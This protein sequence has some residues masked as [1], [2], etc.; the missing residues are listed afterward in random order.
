MYLKMYSAREMSGFY[1]SFWTVTIVITVQ[2]RNCD[3]RIIK[4]HFQNVKKK[5][6]L[7]NVVRHRI[8]F[9]QVVESIVEF[10]TT[11]SSVKT[12]LVRENMFNVRAQ[13]KDKISNSDFPTQV[14]RRSLVPETPSTHERLCGWR[15]IRWG[16]TL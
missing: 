8:T 6:L 9:L 7:R 1:T 13:V 10:P 14:D 4:V 12:S 3:C 16:V 5:E 11:R 15:L 2:L